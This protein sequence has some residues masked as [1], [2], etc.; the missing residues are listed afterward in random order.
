MK[1]IL[2]LVAVFSFW[3]GSVL[4]QQP[5][6]SVEAVQIQC[7]GDNGKLIIKVLNPPS[8]PY[9]YTVNISRTGLPTFSMTVNVTVAELVIDNIPPHASSYSAK[10]DIGNVSNLYIYPKSG[11]AVGFNGNPYS[12]ID[13]PDLGKI[14]VNANGGTSP[15]KYYLIEDDIEIDSYESL[16][17]SENFYEFKGLSRDNQ[18]TYK[19]YIKDKNDCP[20]STFTLPEF[21]NYEPINAI[22]TEHNVTC[23]GDDDGYVTIT[24]SGGAGRTYLEIEEKDGVNYYWCDETS[25]PFSVNVGNDQYFTVYDDGGIC[26]VTE[27]FDI[28]NPEPVDVSG[29]PEAICYN[30]ND[31]SITLSAS[32]GTVGTID[33]YEY[34]IDSGTG[35][36]GWQSVSGSNFSGLT[37]GSTH[38][39]KARDENDCESNPLTITIP[40]PNTPSFT[41]AQADQI[42]CASNADASIVITAPVFPAAQMQYKLQI[43]EDGVPTPVVGYENFAAINK[44]IGLIA[45][46]YIVTGKNANNCEWKHSNITIT[47]PDSVKL[48]AVL[49]HVACNGANTG[50]ITLSAEG[51]SGAGFRFKISATEAGLAGAT[52]LGAYHPAF[53]NLTAGTYWLQARDDKNCVSKKVRIEIKEPAPLTATANNTITTCQNT[54]DGVVT[55]RARG[56]TKPY[57]F[58][59][60]SPTVGSEQSDSVF[61]MLSPAA[62]TFEVRDNGGCPVVRTTATVTAASIIEANITQAPNDPIT[63]YRDNV[64]LTVNVTQSETGRNL[65]YNHNSAGWVSNNVFTTSNASNSIEVRYAAPFNACPITEI[66]TVNIPNPITFD[67][68]ADSTS[69]LCHD[70]FNGIIKLSASGGY[71]GTTFEYG[72]SKDG[73]AIWKWQASHEFHNLGG[74]T[75]FFFHVRKVYNSNE[76]FATSAKSKKLANPLP[77]SFSTPVVTPDILCPHEGNNGKIELTS[78][79][80]T[81]NLSYE[82]LMYN[83]TNEEY[84]SFVPSQTTGIFASL[85]S[86]KYAVKVTDANL[87]SDT[88]KNI[89]V[90]RLNTIHFTATANETTLACDDATTYIKVAL[91]APTIFASNKFVYRLVGRTDWRNFTNIIS[92]DTI[93]V[94][95]GTYQVEMAYK[96]FEGCQNHDASPAITVTVNDSYVFDV[97]GQNPACAGESSGFVFVTTSFSVPP[98]ILEL[99]KWNDE[100]GEYVK[101]TSSFLSAGHTLL[102]SKPG[103]TGGFIRLEK[104]KYMVKANV[105]GCNF[106]SIE[107]TLTEPDLFMPKIVSVIHPCD[108]ESLNGE[109]HIS[110]E[111]GTEPYLFQVWI[112]NPNL[113]RVFE[114]KNLT[115][116]DF[117]FP[118]RGLGPDKYWIRMEDENGCGTDY[119]SFDALNFTKPEKLELIAD[120]TN[121]NLKHIT[122]N[123]DNDG[124]AS[125]TVEGE[126]KKYN[127]LWDN[128]TETFIYSDVVRAAPLEYEWVRFDVGLNA[129]V[130]WTDLANEDSTAVNLIPGTY[131]VTVT[132]DGCNL[133][134]NTVEFTIHEPDELIINKYDGFIICDIEGLPPMGGNIIVI[135]KGGTSFEN[136]A[137][138]Y[139]YTVEYNDGSGWE[140]FDTTGKVVEII[141]DTNGVETFHL[142]GLSAD[143]QYKIVVSDA[144]GCTKT[145]SDVTFTVPDFLTV[146]AS[147]PDVACF[148]D[149]IEIVINAVN[150]SPFNI[151]GDIVYKLRIYQGNNV[152]PLDI[153]DEWIQQYD[154]TNDV[155]ITISSAMFHVGRIKLRVEIEDS[156]GCKAGLNAPIEFDNPEELTVSIKILDGEDFICVGETPATR[157]LEGSFKGGTGGL[158]TVLWEYEKTP[159]NGFVHAPNYPGTNVP[160]GKYFYEAT[161]S[162]G[163]KAHSD[164]I[165]IK[166]YISINGNHF[167]YDITCENSG[168]IKIIDPTGGINKTDLQ[169]G[170]TNVYEYKVWDVDLGDY[171]QGFDTF[172]S[173][174]NDSIF[175]L[176]MGNYRVEIRHGVIPESCVSSVTIPATPIAINKIFS[177]D[178]NNFAKKLTDPTCFYAANGKIEITLYSEPLPVGGFEYNLN[179]WADDATQWT[180]LPLPLEIDNLRAGEY[181]LYIK[182]VENHCV[183]SIQYIKIGEG[184][185]KVEIK[186]ISNYNTNCANDHLGVEDFKNKGFIEF[187]VELSPGASSITFNDFVI[188]VTNAVLDPVAVDKTDPDK[189][190]YRVYLLDTEANDLT[191]TVAYDVCQV[192]ATIHD[193]KYPK[194]ITLSHTKDP[195]EDCSSQTIHVTF[196]IE[197]GEGSYE[198]Y[199]ISANPLEIAKSAGDVTNYNDNLLAGSYQVF[200]KDDNGCTSNVEN[201]NIELPKPVILGDTSVDPPIPPYD[202]ENTS[203]PR[204]NDGNI[205]LHP[206]AGANYTYFWTGIDLDG[207]PIN[208]RRNDRDYLD[209]VI[210]GM[211]TVKIN[212]SDGC[213]LTETIEVGVDNTVEITITSDKDSYCPDE[214]VNLFGKIEINSVKNEITSFEAEWK[215]PQNLTEQWLDEAVAVKYVATDETVKLTATIVVPKGSCT[216]TEEFNA[217]LGQMPHLAFEKDVMYIPNEV[218]D[219]LKMTV[220]NW[221]KWG[222][223]VQNDTY[224][225]HPAGLGDPN[226]SVWLYSPPADQPYQLILTLTNKEGCW[227]SDTI[228]IERA[229][230]IIPT[231]AFTPNNDSFNDYWRFINLEH[232]V[233]LFR[234]KVVVFNRGG[235]VIFS[236]NEYSN[237]KNVA[238][239]GTNNG[240]DVPTGNYSF[241]VEITHKS[242]GKK[243]RTIKGSVTIMR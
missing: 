153:N 48:T 121:D 127:Y 42:I 166:Q 90:K 75:L 16:N 157:K 233:S 105:N 70:D 147:T 11:T 149:D 175:G 19:V 100:R 171:L 10:S 128:D 115:E 41:A 38:Q 6:L 229:L 123:G 178:I 213:D 92:N 64:T 73:G 220:E 154:G 77:I 184:L 44:F 29:T 198:L 239:N 98:A 152:D 236:C 85:D 196:A 109:I 22:K 110:V 116:S 216:F 130:P 54:T 210:Q 59:M 223:D 23:H 35:W 182:D 133:T 168:S 222:G 62:Y 15:Y 112:K 83:Y 126:R 150:G 142:Y 204:K 164:T 159:A 89:P 102:P 14:I 234:V 58:K 179:N 183:D 162:K 37:P 72:I 95:A 31:G 237:D 69:V 78:T 76:C 188:S 135:T 141:A 169:K 240:Q 21:S 238:W 119:L 61:S 34:N 212:N 107:V 46:T 32:G 120:V 2:Y 36:K 226:E 224:K 138:L 50:R 26:T 13:C 71:T 87:C 209:D 53:R 47:E 45:G 111:G 243:L 205:V 1:R 214:K 176:P 143:N 206:P 80:G 202:V 5:S 241:V 148:G 227:A 221:G 193:V 225:W 199:G 4:G 186:N 151:D 217:T 200:V 84:N 158:T 74:D 160:A 235:S 140:E 122:C 242:S 66:K 163:C 144:H 124:E 146:T 137:S 56:G 195:A 132:Q 218:E 172:R 207:N 231:N 86:A 94:K 20:S 79:G 189:W 99:Y 208:L 33:D 173:W 60:I 7:V 203:C 177:F 129:W 192:D 219:E 185:P 57:S 170:E 145:T 12:D 125:A 103:I 139:E 27:S 9:S 55:V 118:I 8:S 211:Y 97:E 181:T 30:G 155:K 28:I 191:I 43:L 82:L 215:L 167:A 49:T 68:M 40:T 108:E 3:M 51:G 39:I 113:F 165:I 131:R 17:A 18:K 114:K 24:V 65:E 52:W 96:G 117:P 156:N 187:E 180:T 232:Y 230:D 101:V 88:V 91:Q 201:V 63:C 93:I 81:G 134:S 190:K 194:I 106:E 25:G 104:G 174:T 228:S 161:D 197:G 67:L 136:G